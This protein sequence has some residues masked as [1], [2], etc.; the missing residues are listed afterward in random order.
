MDRE[1]AKVDVLL[2]LQWG[3]EGKGKA[4]DVLAPYYQGVARF[5]GGPNAGHSLE[6]DG[7]K[8]VLRSVP[9]GVF[10]AGVY[11]LIGNGVVLAPIL[12][13]QEPRELKAAGVRVEQQVR[14][15]RKAHLI[16]PTHRYLDAALE[17]MRSAGK[18]GSTGKGIGPAYTSKAAREGVRV[19]DIEFP[20]L[21]QRRYAVA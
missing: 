7:K 17:R 12:F 5:Q 14:I 13:Y 20:E 8:F 1:F 2:G 16:L 4:V 18:I 21:L 15:S 3:D 19:G 10:R 6:F 11:N 9:S